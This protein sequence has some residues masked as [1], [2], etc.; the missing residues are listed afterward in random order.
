M[1][2][3]NRSAI[4]ADL[5][6]TLAGITLANGYKSDVTTVE[7][8]FRDREDARAESAAFP[9]IGFVVGRQ[10]NSYEPCRQIVSTLNVEI[11]GHVSAS[12]EDGRTDAVANLEDDIIAA[13]GADTARG[14]YAIHTVVDE[15]ETDESQPDAVDSSGVAA[16][17]IMRVRI[18]YPRTSEQS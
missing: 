4:I 16:S 13:L 8:V 10:T 5:Q 1:G 3:P 7:R 6:T 2:Q 9:W 15:S 17:I 18:V 11:I 12:T 14:G